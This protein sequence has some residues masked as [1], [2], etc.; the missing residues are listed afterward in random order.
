M[1]VKMKNRSDDGES[2]MQWSASFGRPMVR[3]GDGTVVGLMRWCR[4]WKR[5]REMM[6]KGGG[7]GDGV[8]ADGA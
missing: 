7:C 3:R 5:E 6:A 1:V 4:W 8:E 2:C